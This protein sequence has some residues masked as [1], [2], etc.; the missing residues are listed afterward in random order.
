MPVNERERIVY[1]QPTTLDQ[2]ADIA[3]AC[4]VRLDLSIPTLIDQISNEVDAAYGALPDRLYL[5]GEEGCIAYRSDPGPRGFL[6]DEFEDA[7][8]GLLTR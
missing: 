5:I 3:D 7:I 8:R 4:A 6:P 1:E 2:R